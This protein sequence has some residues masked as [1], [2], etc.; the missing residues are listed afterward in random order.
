MTWILSNEFRRGHR[1]IPK[2]VPGLAGFYL[3]SMWTDP[4]GGIPGAASAGRGVVQ[5]LCHQDRQ[6][7]VTT[8]P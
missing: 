2:T 4:P 1:Y 3:A 7:F 6:R 5:L 8:T